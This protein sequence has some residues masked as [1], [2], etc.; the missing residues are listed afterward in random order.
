MKPV[1]IEF[2]MRDNLTPGLDKAGK[3]ADTLGE[4][5]E[6][7]SKSITTRISELKAQI[8][9]T[10][11]DLGALKKQLS[12]A[13]PGNEWFKLKAEIEACAKALDEDKSLLAELQAKHSE[14]A[15]STKR[16][17]MELR[18]LQEAMARMRLEGRQNSAEYQEMARRAAELADT[19]G[20][21]RTQTNILAHDDAGIQGA[22]SGINGLSGAF[23]VATGIM[24][25]FASENENLAKIQ[26]RVQ[27]VMAIT[28]GLQ[29]VMNT[30]NKDS[31]FRLVTVTRAKN[32][33]TAANNRLAASLHISNGAATAL[34][35]TLTL[36]LSLAITAGIALWNRYSDAQE[37]AAEKARELAEIESDARIAM[38]KGR[39]EIDMA[40]ESLKNFVGTK[41]QEKAKVEELNRKYGESFGYYS[42]VAQWYDVLLE[43]GDAYVQMLYN[44]AETQNLI[45]KAVEAQEELDRF[46]KQ[47]PQKA[48]TSMSLPK[49]AL[50]WMS[51]PGSQGQVDVDKIIESSNVAAYNAEKARLQANLDDL[52]KRI[53]DSQLKIAT[54]A[55]ENNIGGFSRPESSKDASTPTITNNLADLEKKA[56][57]KIEDQRIELMRQGY[58]RERAEAA[59]R[60]EREKERITA[61]ER[62]CLELYDKLKA[63]G[64]DVTPEQRVNI[65]A[66]A[67]TLR[68]QAAAIYDSALG[69]IDAREQK[70]ATDRLREQESYL[71]E[72]LGKYEDFEAQRARVRAEGEADIAKLAAARNSENTDEIDRAIAAAKARVEKGLREIAD[73]E[74]AEAARGSEF[75]GR[76]F[77]DYA[78]M[79]LGELTKLIDQARQLRDYLNGGDTD[80]SGITF[81]SPEQLEAIEGSPAELEKLKKALD[82]LLSSG[83]K[84]EGKWSR[85][86]ETMRKGLAGLRKAN[87]LNDTA[88][89]IGEIAGAATEAG[90]EFAAML[91]AM[92]NRRAADAVRTV[93]ELTGAIGN[94]GKGFS[95]GGLVGGATAALGELTGMIANAF[96]AQARHREA[97]KEIERQQLEFQRE[98]NLL[99]MQQRLAMEDAGNVFGERAVKKAAAA[100]EVYR[101]AVEDL[102]A[103]MAGK[104][105]EM[106]PLER[107]SGDITGSYSRRMAEY[108][109]GVAALAEARIVTGHKK[110]GLFGWGKGKDTYSGLLEVYPELIKANGE[111]D[112]EML[113]VILDTRKM[114]DETRAYL[115]N[116][117]ELQGAM[118]EAEASLESYLQETFGALG[119][120]IMDAVTGAIRGSEGA[121]ESFADSASGTLETLGRQIAYSLFFA[122]SFDDLQKRLKEAYG[123]GGSEEEIAENAMALLGDFYA[124]IGRNMEDAQGWLEAWKAKASEMGFDL[125]ESEGSG[126]TGRA[127]AFTAISQDQGT[128]L[129]GLFT[130]VQ[131]HEASIDENVEDVA[132]GLQTAV[133]HLHKIEENT[134]ATSEK[135]D[136]VV[137]LLEKFDREGIKV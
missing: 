48:E 26:T 20:D 49:Q 117:I 112:T 6:A 62:E 51:A 39:I 99:L 10:E 127:G 34:M 77:G 95:E 76:L 44:Q 58:E 122:D 2:L 54:I 27:S 75:M 38:T 37:K 74:G 9:E 47:D 129:E 3:S 113:R 78:R 8:R 41:E 13:A 66:Q 29:Q 131:M 104:E 33:L 18:Q 136:T 116:L 103:E 97:L 23:T 91:D 25:V 107:L 60:F 94:I 40:A 31:A 86:F 61:E 114:S 22:I 1:E 59:L 106:S 19:I 108:E 67:A 14:T 45:N 96:G 126:Q 118:D 63:A 128:K 125:W 89:S 68:A 87:G 109:R 35:G 4:R 120:G 65:S 53:K 105:P 123:S 100:I 28:M 17:S 110:T 5:A 84:H 50:L 80:K 137:E 46:K 16:L 92:G 119:D 79:S 81:I 88:A 11:K 90:N 85:I 21:L 134:G 121:L 115:E 7:A 70:E 56:Y 73:A 32:L 98:Y 69:D 102:R 52:L 12:K 93:T 133:E 124:G 30:L 111:L 42:T 43:K 55:K 72:L 101:K 135:L 57:Q 82:R 15:T 71:K 130:S 64:K 132:E 83:E 36:G 24:G